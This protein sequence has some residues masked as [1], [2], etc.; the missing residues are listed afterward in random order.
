MCTKYWNLNTKM[1]CPNCGK[2]SIWNL[3]THFMGDYGS[4]LNEYKLGEKI[5][6]LDNL[7]VVLNGKNNDF[8]RDCPSCGKF[9]DLGA[10]IREGIVEKVYLLKNQN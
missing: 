8:I 10:K 2:A 3:Q 5:K 9:F 6:E 4:C 1:K 7:S